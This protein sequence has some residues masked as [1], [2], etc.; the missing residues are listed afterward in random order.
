MAIVVEALVPRAS[1]AEADVFDESIELAMTQMGGPPEGLMVHFAH[2]A[3]WLSAMQR[4]AER[5]RH[6]VLL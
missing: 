3:G 5:G 6:A 4:V 1:K 2:P